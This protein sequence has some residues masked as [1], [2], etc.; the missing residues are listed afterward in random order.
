MTLA[1]RLPFDDVVECRSCGCTEQH[2][3]EGGC[4]WVP[5]SE[6][7]GDLCSACSPLHEVYAEPGPGGWDE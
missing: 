3:C 6:G 2:A 4:W 5:D 7:M 1:E